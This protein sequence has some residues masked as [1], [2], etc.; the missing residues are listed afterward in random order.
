MLNFGQLSSFEGIKFTSWYLVINND[1]STPMLHNVNGVLWMQ[2]PLNHPDG[3]WETL[4]VVD[5]AGGPFG[6]LEI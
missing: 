3:L 1:A 2:P 5:C 6:E 4:D